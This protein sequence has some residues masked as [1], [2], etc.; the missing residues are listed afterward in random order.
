MPSRVVYDKTVAFCMTCGGEIPDV[1]VHLGQGRN[2]T[3]IVMTT[4]TTVRRITE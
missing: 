2:K 1:K 3:H 4:H